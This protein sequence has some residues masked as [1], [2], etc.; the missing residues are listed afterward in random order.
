MPFQLFI[1]A[2]YLRNLL[3]NSN[4]E[5]DRAFKGSLEILSMLGEDV[6]SSIDP[7]EI[8]SMVGAVQSKMMYM[9][10]ISD[11]SEMKEAS[12]EQFTL[13]RFYCQ[14]AFLASL[15][16]NPPMVALL[17][18]RLVEISLEHG[19]C[20]YTAAGFG[21]LSAMLCGKFKSMQDGLVIGRIGLS[22]LKRYDDPGQVPGYY[23]A[24]YGFV[25][26][27]FEK[28]E[29]VAKQLRRGMDIGMSVG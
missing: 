6:P 23:L 15:V 7:R 10:E 21:Y 14:S 3:I 24:Y 19:V 1:D 28:F 4:G 2:Y 11:F 9:N 27:L 5:P 13:M 8:L 20:K 29:F 18:C 22:Y 26:F 17:T 25:A 12:S 16:Q